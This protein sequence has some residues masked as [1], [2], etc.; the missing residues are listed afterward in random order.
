MIRWVLRSDTKGNQKELLTDT[1]YIMEQVS[2]DI[3]M[4]NGEKHFNIGCVER[5]L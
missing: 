1:S 4:H 2:N 3:L 5:Y